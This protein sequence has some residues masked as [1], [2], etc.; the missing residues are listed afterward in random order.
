MT[1]LWR[2]CKQRYQ[3]TAFQGEGARREGGRWNSPGFP[4]VYTSESAALATLEMLVHI[5]D[6]QLLPSYVLIPASIDE[7]LIETLDVD[8]LPSNWR[9]YPAP[10]STQ[11]I[12]DSWIMDPSSVALRVPS[13]VVPGDNVILNPGHPEFDELQVGESVDWDFDPRLY[14]EAES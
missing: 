4:V 9:Q 3:G 5:E 7:S 8:D 11:E 10:E 6:A 13:V 1:Q 2:I 12:G 14:R